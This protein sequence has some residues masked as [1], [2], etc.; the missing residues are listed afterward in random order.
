MAEPI[1]IRLGCGRGGFEE[2]C[3]RWGPNPPMPRSN[4]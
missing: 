4:F 1:E 3:S 2:P